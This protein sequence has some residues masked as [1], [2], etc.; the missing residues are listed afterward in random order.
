[1]LLA[2]QGRS[3][4][5]ERQRASPASAR[6]SGQLSARKSN[7][8]FQRRHE[9]GMR[10]YPGADFF[11]DLSDSFP[12]YR[13]KLY[14]LAP[15]YAAP[16]RSS[17]SARPLPLLVSHPFTQKRKVVPERAFKGKRLYAAHPLLNPGDCGQQAANSKRTVLLIILY[18]CAIDPIQDCF[19][20]SKRQDIVKPQVKRT[21]LRNPSFVH[22][23][24]KFI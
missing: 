11:L 23:G 19:L 21:H 8:R 20:T 6:E 2:S 3:A 16:T 18:E 9:Y 24:M 1:M 7:A 10:R 14:R 12:R 15:A 17:R 4:R 5:P 22:E 13:S